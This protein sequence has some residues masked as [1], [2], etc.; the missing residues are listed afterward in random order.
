MTASLILFFLV[1]NFIDY[2]DVIFFGGDVLEVGFDDDADIDI[3]V[4]VDNDYIFNFWD[5]SLVDLK[6]WSVSTLSLASKQWLG[7][8]CLWQC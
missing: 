7:E 4:D 8:L 5:F 6:V 2:F 3:V 1:N